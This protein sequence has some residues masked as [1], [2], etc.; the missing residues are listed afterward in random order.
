MTNDRSSSPSLDSH[1]PFVLLPLNHQPAHRSSSLTCARVFLDSQHV[2]RP[3]D[4][5]S[6]LCKGGLVFSHSADDERDSSVAAA[7][8][9]PSPIA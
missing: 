4:R 8:K 1:A 9:G 6:L 7:V 5:W 3:S 2:S